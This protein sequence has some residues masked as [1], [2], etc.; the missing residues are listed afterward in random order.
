VVKY[1]QTNET[2][3]GGNHPY[4]L[5]NTKGVEDTMGTQNYRLLTY[6]D[7][8]QAKAGILVNDRVYDCAAVLGDDAGI[9]SSS[10]RGILANWDTAHKQLKLAAEK[11][12]PA[13]GT[14]L[15]DVQLCAPI[16]YPGAIFCAGANYWDQIGRASCR[17]RV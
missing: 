2:G 8:A 4:F 15:D 17:E 16:L 10:V 7:G 14:P 11:T 12:D 13:Q 3:N 5:T 1:R 6:Q 9:D